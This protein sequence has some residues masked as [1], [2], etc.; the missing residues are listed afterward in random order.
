LIEPGTGSIGAGA[1]DN[2]FVI[3]NYAKGGLMPRSDI[4]FEEFLAMER[5]ADPSFWPEWQRF[6]PARRFAVALIEYRVEHELSQRALAARLGVSQP[7]IAKL[8]SGEHNPAGVPD[9]PGTEVR[10]NR[11]RRRYGR[12]GFGGLRAI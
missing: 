2:M 4:S 3:V 10:G 7:R 8:E 1:F 6:A 11:P 9:G 12:R 5:R